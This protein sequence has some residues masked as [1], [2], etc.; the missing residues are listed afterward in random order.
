VIISKDRKTGKKI[1]LIP[2]LCNMTGLTDEMRANFNLMK[3]LAQVQ[4]KDANRRRQE[5][6]TLLQ[7]MQQFPKVKEK[8]LAW[9]VDIDPKP[10]QCKGQM[11]RA[12]NILMGDNKSF[13]ADC[14]PNDF[15]RAIQ[16]KQ[17]EQKDLTMWA[18]FH[19][20]RDGQTAKQ[21]A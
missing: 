18:I 14:N 21:F 7:E 4:H 10:L 9:K 5:V 16:Q 8:M 12:G 15:D 17:F 20:R 2:E 3:E 1:V 11:M 19:G 6:E 13:A